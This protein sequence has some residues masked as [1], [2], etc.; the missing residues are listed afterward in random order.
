[1]N[2]KWRK[3]CHVKYCRGNVEIY[4]VPKELAFCDTH[5][6]EDCNKSIEGWKQNTGDEK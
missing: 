1:M 4:H 6:A 2:E 5:W 3:N